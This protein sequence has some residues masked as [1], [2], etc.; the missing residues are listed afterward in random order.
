MGEYRWNKI[1][2]ELKTVEVGEGCMGAYYA[3]LAFYTLKIF[4]NKRFLK[5][6]RKGLGT[7]MAE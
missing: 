1:G 4:L 5:S 3:I 6:I 7:K 2:S